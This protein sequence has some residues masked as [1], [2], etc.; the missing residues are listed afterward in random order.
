MNDHLKRPELLNEAN[1]EFDFFDFN[2]YA[3]NLH[4]SLRSSVG[5]AVTLLIGG[6]GTGK[7]VLLN[8][9]KKIS[10]QSQAKHKPKWV[11]FEC[12]QYPDKR[13]LWEGLIL[14]TVEG[15]KGES[16]RKKMQATYSDIPSWRS[17][18]A[19]FLKDI[20][21]AIASIIAIALLSF[22]ILT[23]N[24]EFITNLLISLLAATFVV[25]LAAAEFTL[26]PE[27][28]STIS[29]L[30]D[31]KDELEKALKDHRGTLYIV[32]ED[33]DRAGELGVR[34]FE[35]VSHFIKSAALKQK[36]IKIIVPISDDTNK[37]LVSSADKVSDN[38]LNFKPRYDVEQFLTEVFT[39]DFLDPATKQML[40][41]TI[42]P[43]LGRH[44]NIRKMKH[45]LRNAVTKY[46][47]LQSADFKPH[48][49]IC[50]AVELSKYMKAGIGNSTLYSQ[51]AN[52]YK[53]QPLFEWATQ[54]GLIN[55]S[56]DDPE[57]EID[58]RDYFKRSLDTFDGIRHTDN[59][60]NGI[61]RRKPVYYREYFISRVYFDDL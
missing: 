40:I 22:L 15:V 23:I 7:S 14:E 37:E 35:T 42:N 54:K 20:R 17:G 50:I 60:S 51:A 9:V 59:S 5:P 61:R 21:S 56:T 33:V 10:D 52:Q 32:L 1:R 11:F 26:R 30:S 13:D 46:K 45:T 48:L 39:S 6:Y 24:N 43:L 27:S 3:K 19:D 53:H 18:V 8:E 31:Y 25:L 57:K 29:R 2:T 58:P 55:T 38:I 34:F 47:R 41:S 12:W 49:A 36:S 44:I 16:Q 4:K 28:K